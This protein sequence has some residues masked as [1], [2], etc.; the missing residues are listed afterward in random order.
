[1]KESTEVCVGEGFEQEKQAQ[2]S[3]DEFGGR[4]FSLLKKSSRRRNR[5]SGFTEETS[6]IPPAVRSQESCVGFKPRAQR[7][8]QGVIGT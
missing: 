3:E 5:R 2:V 6:E 8:S 7:R 1:V 4:S